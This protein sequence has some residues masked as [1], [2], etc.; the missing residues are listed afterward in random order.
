MKNFKSIKEYCEA[1]HISPP[2]YEQ[3]DVRSFEENMPTVIHQMLP[4]RHAFY[5]IA[6]KIG[7]EGK[8]I[9]SHHTDFL[10]QTGRTAN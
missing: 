2:K 7:G 5:A 3:F 10:L 1:I 9:T 8:A 4:F 6:L